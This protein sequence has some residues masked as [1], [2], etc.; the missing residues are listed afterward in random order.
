MN[1]RI[2]EAPEFDI[3]GPLPTGVTVLEASART[4]KTYAIAALAAR[5]VAAGTPLDQLLLVTFTRMA[6]SELRDRIREQLT[7]TAA[8]LT[9][10]IARPSETEPDPVIRLLAEGAEGEVAARRDR[11]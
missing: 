5:Y 9:R 2:T 10:L 4:G 11:L 3:C 1:S 7:R 6:T 8:E